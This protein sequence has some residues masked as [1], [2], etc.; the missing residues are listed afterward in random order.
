LLI[1]LRAGVAVSVETEFINAN[2]CG[3]IP[4]ATICALLAKLALIVKPPEE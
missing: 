4:M 2:K 3:S 1:L